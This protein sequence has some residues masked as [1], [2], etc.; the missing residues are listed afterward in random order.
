MNVVCD[1][2][3][4]AQIMRILIDNAITHTPPGTAVAVSTSRADGDVTIAVT[5]SGLGVPRADLPRIFEPFYT[6]DGT[7]GSGLGLTIARDLAE[8]MGGELT[9][10][11]RPG[12]T[13][14]ALRIPAS[15]T[16]AR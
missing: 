8:R 1:P 4:V 13:T 11:S 6:S 16:V 10:S 14:F 3:R 5:D 2:D 9:L 15:P 12:N 7:R